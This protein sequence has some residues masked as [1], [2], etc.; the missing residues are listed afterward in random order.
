MTLIVPGGQDTG[1][2][3]EKM[4][5]KELGSSLVPRLVQQWG[6]PQLLFPLAIRWDWDEREVEQGVVVEAEE[7]VF[8]ALHWHQSPCLPR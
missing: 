2:R 5:C 1:R 4:S 7:A 3:I 8:G 6:W